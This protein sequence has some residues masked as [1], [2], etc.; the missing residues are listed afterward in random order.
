MDNKN[1]LTLADRV[2]ADSDDY[3]H[4]EL[5]RDLARQLTWHGAIDIATALRSFVYGQP[6]G[7]ELHKTVEPLYR[8]LGWEQ[9]ALVACWF[10]D[11]RNQP[12]QRRPGGW[13]VAAPAPETPKTA[14]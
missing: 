11:A 7:S 14:A 2:R 5:A 9:S 10:R 1:W 4:A 12:G 6:G 3:S 8:R 13:P